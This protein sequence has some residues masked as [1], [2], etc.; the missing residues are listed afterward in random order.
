M[1]KILVTGGAGFIGNSMIKNLLNSKF[2]VN[3]LDLKEP[4]IKKNKNFNFFKADIFNEKMI[5]SSMKGCDIVIHLAAALG[6]QNTDK[7]IIDC[8]DTNVF[9]TKKVIEMAIKMK[10][11]RF[12][13]SSSSEV[14]GE[15]TK[16]PINENAELKN[17]SIYATSKIVA[18]KYLKGYAQEGKIK[19]NIIRF[20]NVYGIGQ[21]D[22]FV[23]SKFIKNIEDNK[24][25]LIYGSG[26]QIRSFC[27]VQDAT[28]GVLEVIRNGKNN[29]E[30][31]IGN[32][33]EPISMFNLA[34]KV[35]KISGK[36]LKIKKISFSKS[37]RTFE[38]E[39]FKRYPDLEK[40]KK[41]TKFKPRINLE[42]G[43]KQ[44][45][46][47]KNLFTKEK[48]V[49][50]IGIGTLQF[51]LNYGIANKIGKVS[52]KEIKKIK[53]IAQLNKIDLLDTAYAYG[54]CEKRI[55]NANFSKFKLVTKLPATK[56]PKN[57]LKWV[58]LSIKN[59]MKKLKA[60]SLYCFHIHN[61]KYLLEKDGEQIYKGLKL[62]KTK[63]L[64]KKIGVSIYTIKELNKI[65]GKFKID[66]VLL[67]FNIFDQRTIK[68][69]TLQK[70]KKLGVE[71]H[72]RST[73][74]QGL[75]TMN[76]KDIPSK[77]I[78]Y[79]KYFDNWE[80]ISKKLKKSKV[81]ICLQ[82][83]LSN[84]YID[85]VILGVDSSSQFKELI[86]MSN[87]INFNPNK[88]DASKEIDLINP[89]KW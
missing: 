5:K 82:Y 42:S 59:S 71:I 32:N 57:K 13:F 10:V 63:G 54:D 14:Y 74:L 25:L 62:A 88:I 48:L 30:Y 44:L 45:I 78:K 20:F 28:D 38:R 69:N 86:S 21:K 70:L 17:K 34:K 31:N 50:K 84:P 40:V 61:S 76:K 22:N 4:N 43:I 1:K 85:K 75:L 80:N 73:F 72:T 49:S 23:I 89:S 55:G 27:N 3:C 37:D 83:A 12:I 77:F 68:L 35:V 58:D 18:E 67:P 41:D 46:N 2:Q 6:V 16:F 19:Y 11:K 52:L 8:L 36:K 79:N 81:E 64:I 9:G 66:L 47:E 51:G 29:T 56:P 33:Q 53:K 65:L 7:N 39:I 15:Q 26:K 60:K 87:Y 24:E